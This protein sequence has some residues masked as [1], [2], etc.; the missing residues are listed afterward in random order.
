MQYLE[1]QSFFSRQYF[2]KLGC[3]LLKILILL[4]VFKLQCKNKRCIFNAWRCDGDSDCG[5]GDNSDE[6]NCNYTTP[7]PIP[8]RPTLP[9]VS[10]SCTFFDNININYMYNYLN[11]TNLSCFGLY[12]SLHITKTVISVNVNGKI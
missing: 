9:M 5:N 6:E 1:R 11:I 10:S 12:N 7:I 3:V 4:M 2:T 8:A